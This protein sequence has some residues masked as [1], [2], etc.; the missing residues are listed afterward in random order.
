LLNLTEFYQDATRSKHLGPSGQS[1]G[2][3]LHIIL[4]LQCIIL[5]YARK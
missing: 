5:A 1:S 4:R 3:Q 2:L